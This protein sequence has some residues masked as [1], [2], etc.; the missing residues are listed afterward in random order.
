M[1]HDK[2]TGRGADDTRSRPRAAGI[3]LILAALITATG[4]TAALTGASTANGDIAGLSASTTPTPQ[5]PT[6]GA[7]SAARVSRYKR[8]ALVDP[9]TRN[10]HGFARF[11]Q[12]ARTLR[13]VGRTYDPD[14]TSYP[15]RVHVFIN[16]H[17]V[18]AVRA[19]PRSHHY[20]ITTR[21]RTGKNDVRSV[22]YNIGVGTHN[23]VVGRATVQVR[24]PW[25]SRYQGNQGTAARMVAAWLG[26]GRHV[27]ADQAV[28]SRVRLAHVR[29]QPVGRVRH[30]AGLA[31]RQDGVGRIRLADQPGHPDRLGV[32]LYPR[33][34][35]VAARGL[36]SRDVQ[37]LVL[38]H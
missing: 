4:A 3:A 1:H 21:L 20:A 13:V 7:G 12:H 29:G 11:A 23:K 31:W 32:E 36:G 22:S 38:I 27:G 9:A 25:T 10:P 18:A 17:Q 15:V 8:P 26:P 5:D 6:V 19:N 37:R 30:P 16:G 35:R 33:H 28:E 24:K 14:R 2:R 34:V